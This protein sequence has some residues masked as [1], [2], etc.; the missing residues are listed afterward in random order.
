M[1]NLAVNTADSHNRSEQVAHASGHP[2]YLIDPHRLAHYRQDVGQ[3][4][5]A[6]RQDAQ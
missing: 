5:K 3:R 4:V 6:D 2:V 1:K